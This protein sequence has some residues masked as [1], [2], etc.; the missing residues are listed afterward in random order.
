VPGGTA[1]AKAE[2]VSVITTPPALA[3]MAVYPAR[4]ASSLTARD[5]KI[6]SRVLAL[7]VRLSSSPAA[8]RSCSMAACG[9]PSMT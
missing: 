1:C 7:T 8:S 3:I 5:V 6:Q 4:S 9:Q 2:Q